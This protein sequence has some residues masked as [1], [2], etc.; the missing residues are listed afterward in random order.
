VKTFIMTLSSATRVE[1]VAD[2]TQFVGE[3]ASGQF[4]VLAHHARTATVLVYGLARYCVGEDDWRYLAVP[5]AVLYFVD[6]HLRISTRRF[7]HGGDFR[8][9]SEALDQQLLAEEQALDEV[10]R[11]LR[12]LEQAMFQRLWRM[13]ARG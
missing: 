5:G 12:T 9:V 7:V 10:K 1:L 13:Q 4:G 6:N 3:D 8:K 11:N 2:V